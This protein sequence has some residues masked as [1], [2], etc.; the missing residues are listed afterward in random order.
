[1]PGVHNE[2]GK[3]L[4]SMGRSDEAVV[5]YQTVI[6]LAPDDPEAHS[7]LAAALWGLGRLDEAIASYRCA[8]ALR[9]EYAEVANL[10]M[11]LRVRGDFAE[12]EGCCRRAL[13][14]RPD[15]A[16]IHNELGTVLASM[17]RLDEAVKSLRQAGARP[18]DD[19]LH[20][21]LG[22]VL[23][24]VSR[25]AEAAASYDRALVLW[26]SPR[27]LVSRA[28]LLPIVSESGAAMLAARAQFAAGVETLICSDLT[29]TSSELGM[30]PPAFLL[31]YHGLDDRALQE[32]VAAFY[33]SACPSLAW[34]AP[35][36]ARVTR[37]A[38]RLRV[39]FVSTLLQNST[40]GVLTR[41]LI[42]PARPWAV[43]VTCSMG[44]WDEM[45]AAIG[46]SADR[47]E[48]LSA[49]LGVAQPDRRGGARHRLLSRHRDGGPDVFPGL[50]AA[51]SR[52]VRDVGASGHHGDSHR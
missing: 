47:A 22:A 42:A 7:T 37:R 4:G 28:L 36:C 50:C 31:A 35:H 9:P 43:R 13:A 32:R 3:V 8:V 6:Q 45:A 46:E 23:A 1:M 33:L 25:R 26:S 44:T 38:G 51:G 24:G 29:F 12:A 21:Q 27:S 18:E 41:R 11:L 40:I 49:A 14:L 16:E 19:G 20:H 10:A 15:L 34:T 52:A 17:H 39:G 2:L 30:A 48:R 5:C